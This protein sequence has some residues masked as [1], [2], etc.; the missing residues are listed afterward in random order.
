MLLSL[1]LSDHLHMRVLHLCLSWKII[2]E[3]NDDKTSFPWLDNE[4]VTGSLTQFMNFLSSCYLDKA[5]KF[6]SKL[7]WVAQQS[8]QVLLHWQKL[9][10]H[11]NLTTCPSFFISPFHWNS[12]TNRKWIKSIAGIVHLSVCTK[13]VQ[14]TSLGRACLDSLNNSVSAIALDT[15]TMLMRNEK[16][17]GKIKKRAMQRR[18]GGYIN[19]Y[20][21]FITLSKQLIEDRLGIHHSLHIIGI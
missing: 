9:N 21:M 15:P 19:L 11:E 18:I 3:T 2:G 8:L 20:C 6:P 1:L 10:H 4:A 16:R 12:Y 13:L 14:W 7:S 5:N 17:N